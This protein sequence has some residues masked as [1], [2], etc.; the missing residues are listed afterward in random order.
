VRLAA[1]QNAPARVLPTRPAAASSA[2]PALEGMAP[3]KS[4]RVGG[5]VQS[6]NLLYKVAPAYPPAAKQA[7]IQGTVRFD[8]II[9]ADGFVKNIQVVSGE[10]MLIPAA[11]DAVKQWVYKPTLLNGNPVDVMT[12]VDIN[13]TLA[14]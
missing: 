2:N 9:G 10:P 7:R 13:F 5:N 11:M 1:P 4:I 14:P 8:V 12:V 3:P 6:A